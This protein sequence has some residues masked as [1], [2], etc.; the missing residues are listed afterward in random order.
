M[1]TK[2]NDCVYKVQRGVTGEHEQWRKWLVGKAEG[3]N[4]R[5]QATDVADRDKPNKSKSG[6]YGIRQT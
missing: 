2:Q 1:I 3:M 4:K 6:T 5:E